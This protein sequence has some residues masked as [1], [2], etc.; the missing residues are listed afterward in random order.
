[1]G[2]TK[3]FQL[4]SYRHPEEFGHCRFVRERRV[5][6]LV[7]NAKGGVSGVGHAGQDRLHENCVRPKRGLQLQT[8][9]FQ[10]LVLTHVVY[11]AQV[12]GDEL[13]GTGAKGHDRQ[14]EILLQMIRRTRK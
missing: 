4:L 13:A 9:P 6:S 10:K 14:I 3:Q 7:Q 5:G 1:M 8:E 2:L 12:A 11:L